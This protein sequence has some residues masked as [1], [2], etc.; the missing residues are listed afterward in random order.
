MADNYKTEYTLYCSG[1]Y[2]SH[3]QKQISAYEIFFCYIG[4]KEENVFDPE[5]KAL[6]RL[7]NTNA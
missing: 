1:D 6:Y 4:I 7:H 3:Y 5:S 2:W